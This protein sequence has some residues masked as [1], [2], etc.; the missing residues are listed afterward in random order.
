MLGGMGVRGYGRVVLVLSA[1]LAGAWGCDK[2]QPAETS[3]TSPTGTAPAALT[4]ADRACTQDRD[5][6]PRPGCCPAPCTSDVIHRRALPRVE[7]ELAKS[8]TDE[9]KRSCPSAGGCVT[10]QYLCI[11]GTC[12]IAFEGDERYRAPK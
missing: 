11:D 5:C 3:P 12:G 8:C 4:S 1:V 6:V 7:A 10:H 2:K 9:M